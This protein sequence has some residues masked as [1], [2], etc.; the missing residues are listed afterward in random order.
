MS[1]SVW[2]T[3]SRRPEMTSAPAWLVW[4]RTVSPLERGKLI[5]DSVGGYVKTAQQKAEQAVKHGVMIEEEGDERAAEM[6]APG[7]PAAEP[8]P[9]QA[10]IAEAEPEPGAGK[11]K[12][13]GPINRKGYDDS[14][15]MKPASDAKHGAKHEAKHPHKKEPEAKQKEEDGRV[16]KHR[17]V[18]ITSIH[19]D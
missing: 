2:I 17:K 3:R 11:K 13:R 12:R 15:E 10:V 4:Y 9:E 8:Q 7:E 16:R 5:R 6:P 18:R 1:T 19:S 14:H